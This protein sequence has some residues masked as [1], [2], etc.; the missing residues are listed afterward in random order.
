MD[1]GAVPPEVRRVVLRAFTRRRH[2][3]VRADAVQY[4]YKTLQAHGL[5]GDAGAMAE[6]V[7]ALAH[8]LVEQQGGV[9]AA[10]DG[11]VVTAAVLQRTYERL[12]DAPADADAAARVGGGEAPDLTRVLRVVDAFAMPALRFH[13]ARKVFEVAERAPSLLS[14]A[15]APSAHLGERYELLRSLVLRNEHFLPPLALASGAARG[16]FLQLTTTANLLGRAGTACL[17]FGRLST[18][19]DGAYALEDAEGAVPLDLREAVAGEGLLTEGAFVLVEGTYGADERL[20][21]AAIGHPP[22]E[23]RAA[24]Q[25]HVG[26]LDW[27]GTGALAP[28]EAHALRVQERQHGDVCIAVLSE[29]HLDHPATLSHLRALFQG[30]QDADFV[31]LAMVLCGNFCG[32]RGA[33]DAAQL[34]RYEEGFAALAEILARFPRLLDEMHLVLVPGPD[35]PVATPVLPRARIPAPLVARFER[36]LPRAFCAE[37]VHW[38]SNPCRLV[39]FSQEM[40]VFRDDV[41]SKM[42]RSAL[43]LSTDVQAADLPKLVRVPLTQ[44]V[45]TLLDQAHLCPLP[46]PVRPVLWEYAHALRLYPMPSALVLADRCE[47]GAM[48]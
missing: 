33:D 2:L 4:V 8:A 31:P 47:R 13:G 15:G 27:L 3:Q 41:M 30:Y 21:V 20:H 43:P 1:A 34:A 28:S 29:V 44:L 48:C 16:S 11:Q 6:A 40:V 26:H 18:R 17:L 14:S 45:S 25:A 46:Q 35:D 19:P 7:D 12:V 9:G 32:T 23:S 37:R 22:S 36:R 38:A 42:L 24:A 10:W 5:L 39:Y